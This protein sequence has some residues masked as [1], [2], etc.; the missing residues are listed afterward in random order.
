MRFVVVIVAFLMCF[1]VRSVAQ[2]NSGE[3]TQSRILILLDESSSMIQPWLQGKEKYKAADEIILRL[4]DSIYAVNNSVEF[5]LRVFGHQH[6]VEEHDCYDTKNEVSF[7]KDNRTQMAFR[8]ADLRPLG[9]TP[10]AYAL[11]EAAENDLTDEVHNAY[12]II[13]I[14][15]GGESCGGDI[16][17]VVRTLLAKKVYFKPYIVSLVDYAPLRTEYS[18]LGNFLQVTKQND[19]PVAVSTI[20]EAFRPML[21]ISKTDYKELQKTIIANTPSILKVNMPTVA[22]QNDEPVKKEPTPAVVKE[23]PKSVVVKEQPKPIVKE[24]PKPVKEKPVTPKPEI[25]KPDTMVVMPP[26]TSSHIVVEDVPVIKKEKL[27][28]IKSNKARRFPI[29][30]V[31][32]VY[33]PRK[34][35]ETI[36]MKPEPVVTAPKPPVKTFADAGVQ[37]IPPGVK[38]TKPELKPKPKPKPVVKTPAKPVAPPNATYSTAYD[39]AKETT[40][41]IYF[42][43]GRGKFYS[44]TPQVILLDEISGATKKKFYRTI[45]ANGNPDPQQDIPVGKYNL[46]IGKSNLLVHDVEVKA[47][48]KNKIIVK[49]DVGS[50]KFQY[51]GAPDRPVSEF[52]ATVLERNMPNGKI[53]NQKC[54]EELTY[55]PGNYHVQISTLPTERRN[56]DVDFDDEKVL[57]IDQPGF[58]Q[59]TS[60]TASK[61]VSLYYLL[62]DR[63]VPFYN[64]DLSNPVSQHLQLQPNHYQAHYLKNPNVPSSPEVVVAF[65]IKATETTPVELK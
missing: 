44:S 52:V 15:D 62:G 49:V 33:T 23:E 27:D 8:L 4:M 2:N 10:I 64:V 7:S 11:K 37:D 24:E 22:V 35:P 36:P 59:F 13:L 19:I 43:D 9:V 39:D 63:F 5:S 18:C 21:K 41:E 6:T 55:D 20:V 53:V 17:E 32:E 16:C 14:T 48:K 31:D 61:K 47:N 25:K 26:K 60:G 12:S 42:T 51:A 50:L 1:S 3:L 40:V 46:T 30:Y 54:T 45:D 38:A 28:R 58:A 65:T 57:L 34:V 29:L 56:V